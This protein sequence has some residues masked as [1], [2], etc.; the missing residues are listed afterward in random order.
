MATEVLY[1]DGVVFALTNLSGAYT[2]IDD[3]A[4]TSASD[5]DFLSATSDALS[6]LRASFPTPTGNPTTG[7][8][9][10]NFKFRLRLTQNAP[11]NVTVELRE[12]GGGS[13]QSTTI[14]VTSTA[15]ATYTFSWDAANLNTADGSAVEI[16]ITGG[17]SSGPPSGRWTWEISALEWNVDYVAG[18]IETFTP[19]NGALALEGQTPSAAFATVLP[20]AL[21]PVTGAILLEGQVPTIGLSA[22]HVFAPNAGTITLEGAS[23]D[24]ISKLIQNFAPNTSDVQLVGNT[25]V[26]SATVGS[27]SCDTSFD[28]QSGSFDTDFG[29][30]DQAVFCPVIG[31]LSLD[32]G[33][34]VF[35][36][37]APVVFS[38][39]TGTLLLEGQVPTIGLSAGHVFAPNAGTITLEGA[40]PNFI[41]KLIQNFAPNTS[42][43]QLVGNTPAIL[44][45][46]TTYWRN[47]AD[48]SIAWTQKT[49]Q[50]STWVTKTDH[51]STW[52]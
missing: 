10:Q 14:S 21:S 4:D 13:L 34:P 16:Y 27:L 6:D 35:S 32:S 50:S 30:F 24:F 46:L 29:R 41:S 11:Q 52:S 26:L 8:G 15:F 42:D 43:V 9:V 22:G 20:V 31:S 23:P 49:D 25:P 18:S 5:S 28:A 2:D 12:T 3:D 51:S 1:P 36:G 33:L 44:T 37:I 7:T 38:P 48:S 47:K 19:V 40:S 17:S 39:V 45:T